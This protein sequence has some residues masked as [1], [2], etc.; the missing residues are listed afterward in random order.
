MPPNWDSWGKIRVLREGFDVEA[1]SKGWSNDISEISSPV[2]NALSNDA[3]A[4]TDPRPT[5]NGTVLPIYEST[6]V[7]PQASKKAAANQ[8]PRIEVSVP[9]MQAFLASQ[10]ESLARLTAEEEET[11]GSTALPSGPNFST[12]ASS[13]A[14]AHDRISE[15][16]GPVQVNMG[17][18]QVDADDVV[19]KL[20]HQSA[21][22]KGESDGEGTPK[23]K[24]EGATM[25]TPDMKAQNEALQSFF[26]GLIKRGPS[27]SPRGTPS[28]NAPKDEGK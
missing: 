16:I 18:I 22:E 15:Q 20:Q 17:G 3:Q 25:S 7:D 21:R 12:N 14:A 13:S 1:I 23:G 19:R 8:K 11:P 26:S 24:K 27:N 6:I 4:E 5:S 9:N 28:K 2:T 10:Q